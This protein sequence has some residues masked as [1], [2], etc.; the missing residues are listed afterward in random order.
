M[1]FIFIAI[2]IPKTGA[3]NSTFFQAIYIIGE[4]NDGI[5]ND[6]D[7]LVDYASDPECT[8]FDDLS[9]SS[10]PSPTITVTPTPIQNLR[11]NIPRITLP[12]QETQSED[13]LTTATQNLVWNPIAKVLGLENTSSEISPIEGFLL[14]IIF[15]LLLITIFG[16]IVVITRFLRNTKDE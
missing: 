11:S 14:I 15:F 3:T 4:C 1:I 16:S 8:S 10:T 9:E 7:G 13:V 2:S 6:G 5:D 12:A